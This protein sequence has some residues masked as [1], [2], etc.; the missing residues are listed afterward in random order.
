MSSTSSLRNTLTALAIGAAVALGASCAQA[1]TLTWDLSNGVAAPGHAVLNTQIVSACGGCGITVTENGFTGPIA[2]S[3]G[4]PNT[5]LF[6]KNTGG[7]EIGVGLV[8]GGT[9]RELTPPNIIQIDFSAARMAGVTGFDFQ[10]DSSTTPDAW[11][12]FGSN[13]ATSLGV[14][15][16]T[17]TDE[18]VHTLTGTNANFMFYNF[19]ATAGNVLV[20]S[21]SGVS[22]VPEPA[23]WAMMLLGFAG[24]GFAFRQS[25]RKVSFA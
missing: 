14:S 9:D 19:E 13:S 1:A 16:A 2:L 15:V 17:G 8:N 12:V 11:Q 18:A 22:A 21:V 20:A 4:T 23:T 7:D 24:L 5:A 25:R 3:T 10:M 6:L